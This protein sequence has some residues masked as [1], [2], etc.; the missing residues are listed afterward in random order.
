MLTAELIYL[1]T[2]PTPEDNPQRTPYGVPGET[3]D[4]ELFHH[5]RTAL[6]LT[7][8]DVATF[9]SRSPRS[10]ARWETEHAP[11][12]VAED[13]AV[14]AHLNRHISAY[15]NTSSAVTLVRSGGWRIIPKE[16]LNKIAEDIGVAAR[17]TDDR[18]LREKWWR[19]HAYTARLLNDDLTL[20]HIEPASD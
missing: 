17:Y 6:H 9:V 10:V 7:V 5:L 16:L 15:L 19:S 20:N 8:E 1:E 18:Y 14:I 12:A 3:F 11:V 4:G 2:L 13:L